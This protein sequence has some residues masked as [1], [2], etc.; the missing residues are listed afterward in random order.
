M[1]KLLRR[2]WYVVRQRRMQADLAEEMAFHREMNAMAG[3]SGAFGSTALAADDSH[4]VWVSTWMQD[5]WQDVRF[6]ARVLVKDRRFTL[7]AVL[8]LALGLA[9]NTTI[10]SIINTAVLRDLPFDEPDRL[11]SIGTRDSRGENRGVSFQDFD[12]WRTASG[13][14]IGMAAHTAGAVNVSDEAQAPERVRGAFVSSG[15]FGLLRV[16]PILGRDFVAEDDLTGAPSVAILGYGLWQRRY[17][18][19][20]SVLGDTIRVN[21]VP[22]TVIGIMPAHFRFPFSNDVWRP[23]TFAP[24]AKDATRDRRV[25]QVFGRLADGRTIEHARE[26]LDIECGLLALVAGAF[27][28]VLSI[29]GVQYLGRAFAGRE[30]G[31]PVSSAVMPYWVDLSMNE[32]VLLFV[33]GM[34]LLTT[35][36]SGLVPALHVSRGN[37]NNFLKEGGRGGGTSLRTRRWT[38]GLMIAQIALTIVLLPVYYAQTLDEVFADA[39]WALSVIGG[40]FGALAVIAVVLAAIGLFAI[41]GHAVTQRTQEVGVRIALGARSAEVVWLFMR[42]TLLQLAFGT[43]MGLVGALAAGQLVQN[44]IGRTDPRDPLTLVLVTLLLAVV[45]I[46]ATLLPARRATRIDPIVALRYE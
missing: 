3:A 12:D 11:V 23:L 39:R 27:G 1:R 14:F 5:I 6:A 45:A 38:S 35:L 2:L 20:R 25:L 26:E 24:V 41:T 32:L 22:S 4:D 17:G 29:Y 15:T 10:F 36:L 30:I 7:T 28:L 34:C 40:W 13:A 19:D 31:A 42:R 21:D 18:G 9:V 8:A 44:W 37:T 16:Q 46:A 43:A 33:S